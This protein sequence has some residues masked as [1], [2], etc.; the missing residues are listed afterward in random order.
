M[1]SPSLRLLIHF[2]R[3]LHVIL[4]SNTC[5][6]D[7]GFDRPKRWSI[8]CWLGR[9]SGRHRNTTPDMRYDF[10][11]LPSFWS[12][13]AASA[14]QWQQMSMLLFWCLCPQ[15]CAFKVTVLGFLKGH[16]CSRGCLLVPLL[17]RPKQ[18]ALTNIGHFPFVI[19]LAS[20]TAT[21][22]LRP[23]LCVSSHQLQGSTLFLSQ[24]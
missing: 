1:P 15:R 22:A 9:E 20:Q 2:Y 5:L 10:Q 14:P 24:I 7:P 11:R 16:N 3:F 12:W 8:T 19:T 4:S 21:A 6:F 13:C 18:P 23:P 17:G